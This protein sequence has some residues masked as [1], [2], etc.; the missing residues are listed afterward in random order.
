M[1]KEKALYE[2]LRV[3]VFVL[4]RKENHEV[5]RNPAGLQV[6]LSCSPSDQHSLDEALNPPPPE[7]VIPRSQ[8]RHI[9]KNK[10]GNWNGYIGKRKVMEFGIQEKA[11]RQ[12]LWGV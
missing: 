7:I 10:F 9:W 3:N 12:W 2:A 5:W 6:V 8:R 1:S 4:I 11:A